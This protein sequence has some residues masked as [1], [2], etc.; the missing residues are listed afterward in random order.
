MVNHQFTDEQAF[1]LLSR[2]SQRRNRKLH[3]IALDVARAGAIDLP[4]GVALTEPDN[5]KPGL[6]AS[7]PSLWRR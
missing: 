7:V 3:E 5:A 4:P 1:D 2:V 6:L